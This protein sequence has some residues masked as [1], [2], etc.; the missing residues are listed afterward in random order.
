MLAVW[1][2]RPLRLY[3][4]DPRGR[5]PKTH[6]KKTRRLG[7]TPAPNQESCAM[8]PEDRLYIALDFDTLAGAEALIAA[9]GAMRPNYK[10][11]YQLFPLGGYD[12]ARRLKAR[13]AGVFLDLK[14][15]D[16]GA[17]VERGVASLTDI[18][19]DVLTVH[20]DPDT[21]KGAIAGRG[22][23]TSLK[24]HA[25]TVLTSWDATTLTAHRY[26]GD[27][28]DLVLHRAE[29]AA[30]AGADGVIASAQ[31][32]Q[33][34]RARFGDRLSI[35]TPGIRPAGAATNDQKRVVTPADALKAGATGLVVGRP[36][37]QAPDPVAA[38]QAILEEIAEA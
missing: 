22:D 8:K 28:L 29:M 7:K 13:D 5:V 23:A 38:A 12:L 24:V 9:M 32:A 33:A 21:I 25:V 3:P 15:F 17:T 11:G 14:L 36:I 10:I 37:T 2:R 16:I 4:K 27:V 31:E 26:P 1:H 30:E 19:A 6:L 20:A 18:G 34:I 35:I